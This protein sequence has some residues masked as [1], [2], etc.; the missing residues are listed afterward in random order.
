[1]LQQFRVAILY[2]GSYISHHAT[3]QHRCFVLFLKIPHDTWSHFLSAGRCLSRRRLLIGPDCFQGDRDFEGNR[4]VS[5]FAHWKLGRN[6]EMLSHIA[7]WFLLQVHW[8]WVFLRAA[9]QAACLP[10]TCLQETW[11]WD[12]VSEDEEMEEENLESGIGQK[13]EG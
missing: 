7:L 12:W 6:T 8:G 1:M 3:Q 2:T 11:S 10:L 9:F 4:W 5:V 13:R